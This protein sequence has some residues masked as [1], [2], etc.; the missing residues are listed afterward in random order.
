MNDNKVQKCIC[1]KRWCWWI[2]IGLFFL[3]LSLDP[4]G[5]ICSKAQAGVINSAHDA[6]CCSV[7]VSGENPTWLVSFDKSK[8]GVIR[9]LRQPYDGSNIAS[10]H[11]DNG[12]WG[13]CETNFLTG[14][15]GRWY[16]NIEDESPSVTVV[17]S[18]STRFRFYLEADLIY[19]VYDSGDVKD[20]ITC[21]YNRIIYDRTIV[22][23]GQNRAGGWRPHVFA[24][25]QSA[26]EDSIIFA[27]DDE[28]DIVNNITHTGNKS[29]PTGQDTVHA[30]E[31]IRE[32]AGDTTFLC[33][34]YRNLYP[35]NIDMYVSHDE[36]TRRGS[37][38][39]AGEGAVAGTYELKFFYEFGTL[40]H[41]GTDA[42]DR[43]V[44]YMFP[45]PITMT[46]GTGGTW[47]ETR[48]CYQ[49]IDGGVDSVIF[50]FVRDS[51]TDST[52]YNPVIEVA[53]WDGFIPD[54]IS[55]GGV[56]KIKDTDF[57]ADTVDAKNFLIVHYLGDISGSD[58]EIIIPI[59][60]GV[61]EGIN[62]LLVKRQQRK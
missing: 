53:S 59:R 55:V 34:N 50:T 20:T 13:N 18:T 29:L 49:V 19:D 32:G 11:T 39:A 45:S 9:T 16:H 2:S 54:T 5:L 10:T 27:D 47:V 8:G 15:A 4:F 25:L 36:A 41:D 30:Q 1:I 58:T 44:D 48:G 6:N 24:W 40:N 7:W 23:T 28:I 31:F 51:W 37:G 38:H 12:G 22:T 35:G 60:A 42:Q 43:F 3:L 26:I 21:Y 17:E 33:I 62:K 52:V 56:K 46:Y 57:Y 14:G 61:A